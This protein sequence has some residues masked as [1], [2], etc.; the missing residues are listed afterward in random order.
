MAFHTDH[1]NRV[2]S[3]D[4]S[5]LLQWTALHL[6]DPGP[7]AV[8]ALDT[9]GAPETR[10]R[11]RSRRGWGRDRAWQYRISG[12]GI[13]IG[14]RYWSHSSTLPDSGVCCYLLQQKLNYWITLFANV[15][16]NQTEDD[17]LMVFLPWS[18]LKKWFY[19]RNSLILVHY[20]RLGVY[21]VRD[22]GHWMK[23]FGFGF[24]FE[25]K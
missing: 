22:W 10:P 8:Y 17:R 3:L 16:F 13:G 24:G 19:A 14:I 6:L 4:V 23:F 15:I 21:R 7:I 9:S 5:V 11:P 1:E 12:F 2:E 18:T 20:M 25:V